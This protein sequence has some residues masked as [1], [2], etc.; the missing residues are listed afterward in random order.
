VGKKVTHVEGNLI[1]TG[2]KMVLKWIL[3]SLML[4][5]WIDLIFAGYHSV[6]FPKGKIMSG[7]LL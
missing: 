4:S 2:E 1:V 6:K 7:R 3:I 5:W